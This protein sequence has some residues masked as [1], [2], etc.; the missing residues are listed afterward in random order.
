MGGKL[1]ELGRVSQPEYLEIE[2]ELIAYLENKFPTEGETPKFRI[3]RFYS[4]KPDFG[5]VDILLS[6]SVTTDWPKLR[7]EIAQDLGVTNYK[8]KGD[9]SMVYKDKIQVDVMV[10][11]D[12]YMDATWQFLCYND[13]GNL[14]GKHY[15]RFNLKYGEKGL[16][17]VYRRDDGNYKKDILLTRDMKKILGFLELSYDE[18][19]RG[20]ETLEDMFEWVIAC[21]YFTAQP[22]IKLTATTNKRVKLRT[23]MR[24][25]VEYIAANQVEKAFDFK[26]RDEYLP[27]IMNYFS[28]VPLQDLLDAEKVKEERDEI[29]KKK[30]N[31]SLVMKKFPELKGP[32]LGTFLKQFKAQ[33]DDF[34]E[35]ILGMSDDEVNVALDS[36]YASGSY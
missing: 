16:F 31:G 27:M 29:I 20:F 26:E 14:L 22:F 15:R 4:S 24:K 12:E 19:N 10:F 18:W 36:F 11:P 13:L 5:D 7:E 30:F 25:F 8:T 35:A 17:Y 21:K 3:P 28:D 33:Y 34:D 6:S 32:R 23:T 9:L 2:K 1:F